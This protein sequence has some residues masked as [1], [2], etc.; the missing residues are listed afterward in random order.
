MRKISASSEETVDTLF[1][2]RLSI[3]Q[4]RD[5]YRFSLDAPLLAHFIGI[6]GRE[7]IVDLG[8]G[9]GVI[10]ML[11]ALLHPNCRVVGVEL[12]DAMVERARR[13]VE[14]NRLQERVDIVHGDVCSITGLLPANSFDAVVCN[15]P[16]RGPRSGRMNP[17]SEKRLARHEINGSL[18]DFLRAGAYLLR[19]GGRMA[20]VYPA[21]R[22]VDLLHRMRLE[23]IEPKRI[24]WV[25]SF[26][27]AE[28]TLVLVE[29][30]KG[31]SCELQVIRPLVVYALDHQYTAEVK[32]I[33]GGVNPVA[34]FFPSGPH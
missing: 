11:L 5:G 25:H 15:P 8:A 14:I 20:L 3:V 33:L 28:A 27:H 10:A 2:G 9:N 26:A 13:S 1:K 7:R 32:S 34:I 18:K 23:R 17:D 4:R 30:T 19:P 21:A 12:Q 16:Y 6:R 29:G 22:A 24:R 31:G